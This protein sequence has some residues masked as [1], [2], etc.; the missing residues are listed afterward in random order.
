MGNRKRKFDQTWDSY[1][2][3]SQRLCQRT[4]SPVQLIPSS[5]AILTPNTTGTTPVPQAEVLSMPSTDPA[6]KPSMTGDEKPS[7]DVPAVDCHTAPAESAST[8]EVKPLPHKAGQC[9]TSRAPTPTL[10]SKTPSPRTP[11]EFVYQFAYDPDFGRKV[12]EAYR[13]SM[14][15]D[16][17]R[18]TIYGAD[19][20]SVW[21]AGFTPEEVR[22]A[23]RDKL[24]EQDRLSA[25][26]SPSP[27]VDSDWEREWKEESRRWKEAFERRKKR[28][29]QRR[30]R[31]MER[32][33]NELNCE[34]DKGG[35]TNGQSLPDNCQSLPPGDW[36]SLPDYI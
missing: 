11:F 20:T 8:T 15:R 5:Q 28:Q 2:M 14:Y 31:R 24:D 30:M 16:G 10:T 27:E 26:L 19:V 4:P 12:S 36:Q 21:K 33:N 34:K 6:I 23:Y 25:I 29:S 1:T 13:V 22:Q 9:P 35:N 3:P 7:T 18:T 17:L 32:K